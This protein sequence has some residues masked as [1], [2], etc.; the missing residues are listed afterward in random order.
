MQWDD[1]SE[2]AHADML[3]RRAAA[4]Q[5]PAERVQVHA[6]QLDQLLLLRQPQR[7]QQRQPLQLCILDMSLS[8]TAGLLHTASGNPAAKA[9]GGEGFTKRASRARAAR[10]REERHEVHGR[11]C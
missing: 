4:T 1:K 5:A 8:R 11:T 9:T 2:F 3:Q 6:A 10:G 7:E